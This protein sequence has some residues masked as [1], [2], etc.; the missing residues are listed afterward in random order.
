MFN[1]I[2]CA[3]FKNESHILDEWIQHYLF[4]GVDHIYLVNDFSTDNYMEIIEKYS[5]SVT[6][7]HND[8]V[9]KE[10]GRQI[11]IYNKYF[12]QLL[13]CSKW[14]S[15]LDLDEFLYSYYEINIQTIL[16]EYDTYSQILVD[17]VHFG[18]ND[19]ILQPNSVVE[20]FI[21]RALYGK[22][23]EYYS[24]KSIFKTDNFISF[25]I[26]KNEVNGS[27]IHLKNGE[28]IETPKLSI[29]HYN[30]QS[31]EFYISVKTKRG[32]INNWFDHVNLVRNKEYFIH[33]D[34]NDVL[35]L[36]LYEQNKKIIKCVKHNK[37]II[38]K[39]EVTMLIT[40]CNRPFLLD[41]TLESF[42][43]Y[44]TYPIVK[45]IILD[46]SGIIGCNENILNKYKDKLNIIS[47][48]NKTNITQL[49]SIDKMYSYV[50]TKYIFHCEE[51]WEFLQPGFIEKSMAIFDANPNEQIFTIWLR[52]H[53][54]T[55]SHPIIY[56]N[57]NRGYFLMD[58]AFTYQDRGNSYTWCG[59]TFN[60]GLRKISDIYLFHP[61]VEKCKIIIKNGKNVPTEGEYTINS[62]YRDCG[63]RSYILSDPNGHVNHIGWEHHIF[64]DY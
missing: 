5:E 52:P 19:H 2:V 31:L 61:F 7:F 46:D 32:D 12:T 10:V 34:D 9:T 21:M 30:L 3:V 14:M 47:L 4:H 58:P 16:K 43:K 8:I 62:I 56:D 18:S 37:I 23:K 29:N 51:D 55:S 50:N 45:T 60:P 17:W 36:K 38:T 27:Q 15:I 41:K 63:Y 64:V 26:H 22:D 13:S 24:Y 59:V 40:S 53:H 57:L 39:N 44:N 6:L 11:Y 49:R 35:D 25:G 1:F 28:N 33:Y 48:Y 20:G 42:V 54:E